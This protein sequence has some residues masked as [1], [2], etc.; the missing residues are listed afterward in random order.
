M[1]IPQNNSL[2]N[3]LTEKAAR[4]G[5][6]ISGIF[7][8]TPRCNM[9]CRMCYIRM[10]EE[11]LS[12]YGRERTAEE[13]I[14]FGR[15]CVNNGMLFLLL[16]GGEPFIR[17]DFRQIYSELRSMGLYISINTNGILLT[18]DDVEFLKQNRSHGL[19]ITLYGASNETYKK[20]CRIDNG[21]DK[22]TDNIEKLIVNNIPV[23]LNVC[24]TKDNIGDLEKIVDFGNIHGLPLKITGYMFPPVRKNDGKG[25]KDPS[26]F[27]PSECGKARFLISEA[28]STEEHFIKLREN[29][30]RNDFEL[31]AHGDTCGEMQGSGMECM[32]G[33]S[34]F[35][36]TW[37]G[38]MLPCGMINEPAE[39]PFENGFTLCWERI[40]KATSEV[41]L[42]PECKNCKAKSVCRPCGA[43]A[44]SENG[45]FEAVPSYL[46]ESTKE[47]IRLMQE[48]G[49]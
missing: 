8:L 44:F 26:V 43:A 1:N 49:E 36:I 16:T 14:A 11:E 30:R 23:M 34:S 22:V 42:A 35:W 45:N 38:R 28:L 3:R 19:N 15:E 41:R 7:E 48:S 13:W 47:Y 21:F 29:F 24:M 40:K 33:K 2:K 39:Y 17:K 25:Q 10:S 31:S 46:C 32:A 4:T 27:T 5:T 18:D 9:N 6:P 20:I 37:D 12:D